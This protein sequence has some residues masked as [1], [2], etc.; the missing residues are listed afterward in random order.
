MCESAMIKPLR[1]VRGA[2]NQSSGVVK[3]EAVGIFEKLLTGNRAA[4][5][6]AFLCL[7]YWQ[8]LHELIGKFSQM[9]IMSLLIFKQAI[10]KAYIFM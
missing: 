7:K 8:A 10:K 1:N 5:H 4:N 2:K 6:A 3:S 9:P